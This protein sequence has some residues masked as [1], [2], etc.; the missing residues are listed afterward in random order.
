MCV[1]VCNHISMPAATRGAWCFHRNDQLKFPAC[2]ILRAYS[3]MPPTSKPL[4]SLKIPYIYPTP[5]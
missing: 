2:D 3:T 4:K 1:R 5:T